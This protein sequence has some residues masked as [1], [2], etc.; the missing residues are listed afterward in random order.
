M[1]I[2]DMPGIS[3]RVPLPNGAQ[4][5]EFERQLD[6]MINEHMSYTSIVTWV[7]C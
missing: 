6:I 3:P 7:S 2:Q 4:Q 5:Q 1:V